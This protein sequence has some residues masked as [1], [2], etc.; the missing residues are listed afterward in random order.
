MFYYECP[1]CDHRHGFL[2]EQLAHPHELPHRVCWS[3]GD[4]GCFDCI[5]DELCATCSAED[6]DD[7]G[8]VAGA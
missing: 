2:A 6:I 1:T 3:C 4:D 7:T 8:L 5:T